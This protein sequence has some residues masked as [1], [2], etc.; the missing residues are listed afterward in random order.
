M[1]QMKN[2]KIALA[3]LA[4]VSALAMSLSSC[5]KDDGHYYPVYNGFVTIK[6]AESGETYFQVNEKTTLEPTN[7]RT[8]I[9]VR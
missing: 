9:S 6:T 4:A 7:S 5:S 2:F 8:H 3:V 1:K